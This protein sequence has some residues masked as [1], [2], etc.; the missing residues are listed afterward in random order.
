M[1]FNT[2]TAAGALVAAELV[3]EP[4]ASAAWLSILLERYKVH[5]PS[6]DQ[7]AAAELHRWADGLRLAFETTGTEQAAAVDA[8][9][10]AAD[11]R[12]RLVTHDG[13]PYHLH[14]APLDANVTTRVKALTTAGLA[15]L[16]A[17]GA[18]GRLG[19][20]R[21]EGCAVVFVDTSRNGRR[22]FCSVRCANAVNVQRH[23]ARRR[24]GEAHR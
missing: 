8:L 2:Y 14:Y 10:V 21:R 17:D 16:I 4:S 12:P 19:S 23:R 7:A 1:Q 9:F 20:C 18:A 24:Y 13:L 11:C 22:T 3:N 5:R 15:Q 6:M